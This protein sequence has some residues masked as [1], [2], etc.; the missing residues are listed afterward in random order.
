VQNVFDTPM[1]ANNAQQF[2][3]V[4]HGSEGSSVG[5]SCR[6]RLL[7]IHATALRPGK[8]GFGP[9]LTGVT[10]AVRF[11][12]AVI[13]VLGGGLFGLL[14]LPGSRP[15]I[16][17]SPAG[18]SLP[19][20]RNRHRAPDNFRHP[21]MTMQRIRRD[22]AALQRRSST[23]C[24]APAASLFQTPAL[25]SAMRH[26]APRRHHHWRHRLWRVGRLFSAPAIEGYRARCGRRRKRLG[27]APK[28]SSKLLGSRI[29][30]HG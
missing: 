24:K 16:R 3:G 14:A 1:F 25:T 20:R 9:S 12:Y 28:H 11:R 19:P 5:R 30:R 6:V 17:S 8:L 7:V 10:V 26:Y 27:E 13:G 18:C 23:S 22:D 29:R 4:Q 21:A 2:A 15:G